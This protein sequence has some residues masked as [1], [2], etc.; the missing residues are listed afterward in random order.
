MKLI[1]VHRQICNKWAAIAREMPGRTENTIKNHWN[2]TKRRRFSKR[3]GQYSSLLQD[4]I[5]SLLSDS[6]VTDGQESPS[7]NSNLRIV[8]NT[9]LEE[10]NKDQKDPTSNSDKAVDY[11]IYEKMAVEK[12]DFGSML[13][14][15]NKAE[16]EMEMEM[17]IMPAELMDKEMSFDINNKDMKLLEMLCQGIF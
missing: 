17:E 13:N 15:S 7:I 8:D 12:D 4:Y 14:E 9:D 5:K 6:T 10:D 16:L 3:K 2:E 1:D 11:Q